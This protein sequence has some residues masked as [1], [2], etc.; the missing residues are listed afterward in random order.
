MILW[1][2][3]FI[4]GLP[5]PMITHPHPSSSANNLPVKAFIAKRW[6]TSA[7]S[8]HIYGVWWTQ[9]CVCVC[10]SNEWALYSI[11]STWLHMQAHVTA[12]IQTVRTLKL[13]LIT[14][15]LQ[16]IHCV[17]Y[18]T[19]EMIPYYNNHG[20]W[21]KNNIWQ[22]SSSLVQP[23]LI[24]SMDCTRLLTNQITVLVLLYTTIELVDSISRDGPGHSI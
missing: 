2:R 8:V 21:K 24:S 19:K 18:L 4:T 17:R 16:D 3:F 9:V 23:C 13:T 6:P 14:I 1:H 20:D 5:W 10:D 7:T 12:W 22:F 15:F 11:T